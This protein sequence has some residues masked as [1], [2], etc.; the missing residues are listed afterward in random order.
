M[1]HLRQVNDLLV[2]LGGTPTSYA[3]ISRT[4][5]SS[6][7]SSSKAYS[8]ASYPLSLPE[9]MVGTLTRKQTEYGRGNVR[10]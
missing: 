3:R 1:Q 10:A 2:A 4:S 8:L 5:R 9:Y 6:I 7:P